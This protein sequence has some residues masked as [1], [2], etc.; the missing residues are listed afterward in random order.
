MVEP[1]DANRPVQRMDTTMS[2]S[3]D[4]VRVHASEASSRPVWFTLPSS[5]E[6]AEY[7]RSLALVPYLDDARYFVS[8]IIRKSI[9]QDEDDQFVTLYAKYLR[10]V[11]NFRNY[12]AVR[13]LRLRLSSRRVR[14]SWRQ[15]TVRGGGLGQSRG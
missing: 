15:D 14:R 13:L 7:L 5:F 2:I 3:N 6:A 9:N 8:L 4:T 12:S 10:E 11:M 1:E